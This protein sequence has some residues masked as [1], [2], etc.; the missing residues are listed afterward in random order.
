MSS[1]EI[2]VSATAATGARKRPL[3][4]RD[5]AYEVIKWRI[6]TCAYRP[7]ELINEAQVAQV[8]GLGRTPVHQAFDRLSV[9]GLVDIMPRK[10]M[11]VR[12]VSLGEM[13]QLVPVRIANEALCARLAAEHANRAELEHLERILHDGERATAERDSEQLLLLDREFHATLAAASRNEILEDL[14]GKLHERCLRFWFLSLTAQTQREA[15][16]R[17][18][19][20]I[21]SALRQRDSDRAEAAVRAHVA[22][23]HSSVSRLI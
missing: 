13:M 2:E 8:T 19:A 17:E 15:V 18:H 23:F 21:V 6:L 4:L 3:S 20:D 1:A 22:S 14:L 10:G 11:V 7:G 5:Q 12:H 16:Q 9:E